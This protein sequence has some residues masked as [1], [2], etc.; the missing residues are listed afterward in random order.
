MDSRNTV[1][2]KNTSDLHNEN[3][4]GKL[5]DL[6][7]KVMESFPFKL[8]WIFG[9]DTNVP[10]LNTSSATVKGIFF[11]AGSIGVCYNWIEN[12]QFMFSGHIN[13]ISSVAITNDKTYIATA[14]CGMENSLII[15]NARNRNIAFFVSGHFPN[16]GVVW[17][18]FSEDGNI[19]LTL[20]KRIP[21][22]LS[23]WNW[24]LLETTP[25]CTYM[26]K[27]DNQFQL[28]GFVK[29]FLYL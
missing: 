22:E 24:K 10:V 11:V 5:N 17:M 7:S 16:E 13:D 19:L 3:N 6:R 15:W 26:F 4:H 20:S 21:Q 8:H 1:M 14:D 2:H 23:L 25:Y 29:S 9:Y 27:E 12:S 28:P 18:C